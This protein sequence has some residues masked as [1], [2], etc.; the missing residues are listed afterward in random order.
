MVAM[1]EDAA[2]ARFDAGEM[3]GDVEVY[4]ARDGEDDKGTDVRDRK[5]VV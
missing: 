4:S 3:N 5:S 1:V 2:V